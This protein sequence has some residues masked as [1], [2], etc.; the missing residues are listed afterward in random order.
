MPMAATVPLMLAP[1]NHEA[2]DFNG[3]TYRTR[4]TMPRRGTPFYSWV[5]GN[6]CVIS[7]AAGAFFGDVEGAM[8]DIA[9][10]LVWMEHALARAAALRAAGVIDFIVVTQ[11]FPSFTHEDTRGPVSADRVVAAE[12][13]LQRYQVDLLLVGHDHMYQRS[14]PMVYGV[15]SSGLPNGLGLVD[16]QPER[17]ANHVGYVEVIAGAGGNGMYEFTEVD[18]LTLDPNSPQYGPDDPYLQRR[19]P[20]LAAARRE[21][22]FAE[23]VVE[24]PEIQVTAYGWDDG[25]HANEFNGIPDDQVPFDGEDPRFDADV[26]PQPI[27]RFTLVRKAYAGEVPTTPRPAREV[28]ADV[29]EAHGRLVYDAA[30]DC[31]AHDH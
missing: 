28:L 29:P 4:F 7:T 17:F 21:C 30:E 19:L 27:D 11:H 5:H 16:G 3:Q 26:D 20:W 23:Y 18:T 2:K 10:E 25:Y 6:V 13:Q 12:Q 14:Y 8:E 1:G 31:T 9:N 22:S 15:P 24:G